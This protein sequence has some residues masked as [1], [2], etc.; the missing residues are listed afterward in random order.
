MKCCTLFVVLGFTLLVNSGF[1]MEDTREMTFDKRYLNMPVRHGEAKWLMSVIIDGE[2]VREFAIELSDEKPDYWVWLDL[3]EFRGKK[4]TLKIYCPLVDKSKVL[5]AVYQDDKIKEA[6][7]FYKEKNRQQFHFSSRRGWNNDS[8]GMVYYKGEYHLFYQHNPYGWNWGNMTWGH[9]VSTDSVHWTELGDAI[10][11]DKLG[12]IFSGSAVVDHGNTAG[13]Q[14]GD[15]EVLV[16]IYTSAGGTS[17]LSKDQPFTQSIAYSN[18]RG[19]TWK[20]YEGNPVVKHIS[21]DNRDPKVIWHEPTKCWVMVLYLDESK[22]A[23]LSSPDLKNWTKHSE[24]KCFHECP[25]LFQ[26]PVDGDKSKTK[27][28]LYGGSGH[29]LIGDFDGKE[30]KRETESINFHDGNCFYASQTFTNM[31]ESD[32]RRIQIA[33][34]RIYTPYMPFNQCMLFPV[35]LTLRTTDDGVRM[36]AEPID[37]IKNIHGKK[38]IWTSEILKPGQNF[39]SGLSGELF[40]IRGFFDVGSTAQMGFNIRG[41]EVLYD[42]DKKQISCNDKSAKLEPKNGMIAL[43]ILVDRNSIEIFANSGRVYMPMGGVLPE[44]NKKI[45]LFSKTTEVKVALLEIYELNSIWK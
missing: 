45:E 42:A 16:C 44:D 18:D 23:F 41:T 11:P 6:D 4:A 27:W 40:H 39:L 21:G 30:F 32:G 19:R 43:E 5:A 20:V 10:H 31:P 9:A 38:H 8:N 33:W 22:M 3:A 26:L 36:F 35:E 28:I 2:K 15:E 12:T 13:F 17:L 29:Y 14:S 34:G 24:Q 7:S 25:E 37:E 1:A